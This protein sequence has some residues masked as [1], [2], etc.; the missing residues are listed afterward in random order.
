MKNGPGVVLVG[1]GVGSLLEDVGKNGLDGMSKL[2]RGDKRSS[3]SRSRGRRLVS[4]KQASSDPDGQDFKML[5]GTGVAEM[6]AV[7]P[8][9]CLEMGSGEGERVEKGEAKKAWVL[10]ADEGGG[11]GKEKYE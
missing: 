5:E 4:L 11:E 9:F 3:K 1:R 6:S 2:S 8:V 10:E 7:G